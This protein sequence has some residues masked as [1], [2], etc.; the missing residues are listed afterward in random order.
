MS[1][2]ICMLHPEIRVSTCDMHDKAWELVGEGVVDCLGCYHTQRVTYLLQK[3]CL[4]FACE[5]NVLTH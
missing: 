5:R 1:L 3:A 2:F 4:Y